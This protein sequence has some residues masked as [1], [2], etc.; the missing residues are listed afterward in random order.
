MRAMQ[1]FRL[2]RKKGHWRYVRSK[3][4]RKE[5]PVKNLF[6]LEDSNDFQTPEELVSFSSWPPQR[7]FPA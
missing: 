3:G 6:S 7:P 4:E 1:D 5:L 2:V